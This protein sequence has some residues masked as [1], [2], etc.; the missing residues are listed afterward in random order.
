MK[1]KVMG[2]L[3]AFL[4]AG[5]L[6]GCG[7]D[8]ADT[9]LKDL[10]VDKYVTLGVY[11]GVE[12]SMDPISV[13]T[14]QW[15]ALVKDI[16]YNN[17]SGVPVENGI[18]DRAVETGDTVNIDY[19]GKKDGA[20]FAGGT[21]QGANLT[22]GSGKFIAGFEDGLIG[23]MP[24]ETVD[25]DLT[26]P[27]SYGSADLA[28]QAVVFTVTVNCIMPEEMDD[29]IVASIGIEGVTNGD[30]LRQYVYDYLY[31]NSEKSYNSTLRSYVM[32]AFI[33]NCV[34]EE[35]PDTLIEKY[36]NLTRASIEEDAASYGMDGDTFTNYFYGMG[37]EEFAA[38]Y[39]EEAVKQDLAMQAVANR[40]G[41]NIEDEEL[42]TMLLSYAQSAGY[43]T[44]EEY[45][46]E[47]SVEDYRNYFLYDR[48]LDF[49]A[50]NA[51][52]SN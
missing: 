10:D 49:L 45:V 17:A 13:D 3:T 8:A 15:D 51:N 36:E 35:I 9:P 11:K 2:I 12:V 22:I 18:M 41:L 52:I 23:V 21:A 47:T 31:E 32:N 26:F 34:F 50:E 33:Q 28:G 6:A 44:I 43:D 38:T 7:K 48:V 39:A 16:Y 20:A 24:G 25:L 29:A 14:E 30:E 19:E 40:E 37:L 4:T 1:K 27:E 46:G 5:V 42:N